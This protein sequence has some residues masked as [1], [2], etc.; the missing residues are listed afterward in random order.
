[1]IPFNLF[2]I[3]NMWCPEYYRKNQLGDIEI[4]LFFPL[5]NARIVLK[6]TQENTHSI[7]IKS[8]HHR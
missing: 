3:L 4:R 7:P 1:M 2:L 5:G 6:L 8:K